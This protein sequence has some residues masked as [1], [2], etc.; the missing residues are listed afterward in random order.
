MGYRVEY[1]PIKKVRGAERIRSRV[2]SLTALFFLLF[3]V[4]VQCFLPRGAELMKEILIPGEAS[5]TVAAL[6]HFAE[7]LRRGETV[8][9][10][11]LH[12][13]QLVLAGENT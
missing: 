8:Q 5:V 9:N 10:A 7:E 1:Q 4:L 6:D 2:L 13:C 3:C 12:F 11:L